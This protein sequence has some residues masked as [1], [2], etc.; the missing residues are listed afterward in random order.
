MHLNEAL[1]RRFYAAR[2]HETADEVRSLLAS[3]VH[4]R[5]PYPS[6]YGGEFRGVEAVV[7]FL[8]GPLVQE[9]E[10]S[11][12]E[13]DDVVANDRLAIAVVKWWTTIGGETMRGREIGVYTISAGRIADVWFVT[14]D[15]AAADAFFAR[16]RPDRADR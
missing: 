5:D 1:V 4:W 3:D 15:Q 12:L 7:G 10:G 11:G 14:E 16:K 2:E 8:F 13:L 6:P 9:V